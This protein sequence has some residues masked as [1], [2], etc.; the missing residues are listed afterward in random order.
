MSLSKHLPPF[1]GH[2]EQNLGGEEQEGTDGLWRRGG[3][4]ADQPLC[5]QRAPHRR[6]DWFQSLVQQLFQVRAGMHAGVWGVVL[7]G[8]VGLDPVLRLAVTI[9]RGAL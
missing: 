3:W 6:E 8:A 5:V 9:H 7:T 2:K 1:V 4:C